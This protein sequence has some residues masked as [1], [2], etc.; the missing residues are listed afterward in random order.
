M[1]ITLAL[2]K[3]RVVYIFPAELSLWLVQL[4]HVCMMQAMQ[5]LSQCL[6]AELPGQAD[7][8]HSQMQMQLTLLAQIAQQCLV[9]TS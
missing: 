2:Q 1:K 3:A 5:D 8:R 4:D 6:A 7:E 9:M